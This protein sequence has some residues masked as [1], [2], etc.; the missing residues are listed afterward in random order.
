MSVGELVENAVKYG[1][2]LRSA[3]ALEFAL[4]TGPSIVITVV[5]GSTE[6]AR[7]RELASR[8]EQILDA[9]RGEELYVARQRELLEDPASH[10]KLGLYRVVFEGG[11]ELRCRTAAD[12]VV[13]IATK[14]S[15]PQ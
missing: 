11:F 3:A 13:M 2:P 15:P 7:K 8:V 10:G 12:S 9:S 5:N 1:E 14:G 4:E 6:A